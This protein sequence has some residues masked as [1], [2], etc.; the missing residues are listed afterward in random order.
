MSFEGLQERLTALQETTGQLK[1]LI[2]RLQNLKF[3]PGSVPLG[4]D[5]DSDVSA[6]LSSEISQILREEEEELELL[7]EEVEDLRDGRPGSEAEHTKTRLK[8]GLDRLRQE[9]KSSRVTFRKAQ[10]TAKRNLT[11]AQRLEREL[12]LQ[13]YSQPVSEA[14][15]PSLG[16]QKAPLPDIVRHRQVRQAKDDWNTSSLTEDD[17]Q[18]VGASN[19]VTNALRQTHERIAAELAR[20]EF[21]HQALE[22]SSQALKQLNESYGSL[23]TMLAS[24]KDLLGTLLRSQKSDTWYLQTALYM[25]MATGAWLLFR[26][27]LYGPM[28]WLVWLPLRLMFNVSIG[29]S[30]AVVKYANSGGAS[31]SV[32]VG[33]EGK[34]DVE[35]LPDESLPTLEVREPQRSAAV[36]GDPE[37]LVEKVGKIVEE[38]PAEIGEE[39]TTEDG[40]GVVDEKP[41]AEVM[42]DPVPDNDLKQG[43]QEEVRQRDE[44]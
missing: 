13:S 38:M 28:W 9:L 1:E 6:E 31:E 19:D 3:Q 42:V 8:D 32:V 4:A 23:D 22:E 29:S 18:T 27:L 43:A 5:E 16:A 12:L 7:G 2:D 15:S 24:S 30:R 10:L 39:A 33:G 21:A 17:K 40:V 37:S 35:G 36:G 25:L 20:S 14:S 11:Q 34:I 41:D 44:L 26:R